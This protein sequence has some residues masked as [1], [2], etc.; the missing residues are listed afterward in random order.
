MALGHEIVR[1]NQSPPHD[2]AFYQP[3]HFVR[4]YMDKRI[5]E[6]YHGY[7]E[8]KEKHGTRLHYQIVRLLFFWF[9]TEFQQEL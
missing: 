2:D 5:Y 8:R 7:L 3:N 4:K 6:Q 1:L 9:Q